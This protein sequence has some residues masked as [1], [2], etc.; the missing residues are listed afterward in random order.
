MGILIVSTNNDQTTNE[1]IEWLNQ[2]VEE[3]IYRINE[4]DEIDISYIDLSSNQ[5]NF[6]ILINSELSVSYEDISFFF[7]RR[8]ILNPKPAIFMSFL[9]QI[10]LKDQLLDFLDSEWSAIEDLIFR[11]LKERKSLGDYHQSQVNKLKNLLIAK[12][13][14]FKIPDTI[15]SNRW[16]N[17]SDF[18]LKSPAISKPIGEAFNIGYMGAYI[19][20]FTVEVSHETGLNENKGRIFPTL[21]QEKIEKWIELRVFVLYEEL[22][23]MA[24]FS[25]NNERTSIDY[26]NY[27]FEKMN[28]MVPFELPESIQRKI[29]CFMRKASLDTGSVDLILSKDKEYVFLE[30]N[31]AGNIEMVS[32]SC[33]Y[34]IEKRIAQRIKEKLYE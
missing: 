3:R 25:Q 27:D 26:R 15:I 5:L 19:K 23:A 1:V 14:G 8:G 7:Y 9:N 11:L 30:V 20:P 29:R 33:N 17:L 32:H 16:E 21:L 18:Y 24:I 13:C 22:F 31:P 4:T 2:F 12:G 34:Y 10:D 28:R 6:N